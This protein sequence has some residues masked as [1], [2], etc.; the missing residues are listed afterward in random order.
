MAEGREL[1]ALRTVFLAVFAAALATAAQAEPPFVSLAFPPAGIVAPR[2]DPSVPHVLPSLPAHA[3]ACNED[4]TVKL[5]YTIGSDG[6]VSDIRVA[7]SSGYADIDAAAVAG[8]QTWRYVPATKDGTPL[9]VRTGV[10]MELPAL[11]HPPDFKADCSASATQ[12]A[13][14]AILKGGP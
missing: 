10:T 13:A 6:T 7:A 11:A 1:M 2:E 4:G 8:A 14:A 5:E 9:A 3:Q 12:A